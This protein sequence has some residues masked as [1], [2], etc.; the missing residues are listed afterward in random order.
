MSKAEK[1]KEFI[2]E[3]AAPVFNKKGYAGTSLNDLIDATGLTKGAIYGNFENK[4][5]VAIAVYQY[6]V[7]RL[8]NR[9][10]DFLL[11]KK[12]M[13]AKLIGLTEFYRENWKNICENGGCPI[14][15]TAV[16]A[17]DNMPVMKKHVQQSLSNWAHSLAR[18]IEKGIERGEIK[19]GVSPLDYGYEI[20][21]LLEGG[22][23]L[24]K[25]MNSQKH[26]HASLDRIIKIINTELKK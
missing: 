21:S 17:D 16:E 26:I 7:S 24:T 20:I 18:V 11:P 1:T 25:I 10:H 13:I 8:N 15:N 12:S 14:L 9:I 5:E 22:I 2:I 6:H 4:D 23:L 19:T 3:K